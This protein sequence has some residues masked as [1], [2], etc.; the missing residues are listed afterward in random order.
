MTSRRRV[1]V[2]VAL[3]SILAGAALLGVCVSG[4]RSLNQLQDDRERVLARDV[5]ALQAAQEAALRLRQLRYHGFMYV[6]EPTDEHRIPVE[7]D[8]A[9]FEAAIRRARAAADQP[10]EQEIIDRI[11]TNY[12]NYRRDIDDPA[13]R[14]TPPVS[15]TDAVAW[16]DTHHVSPLLVPC[17]ELLQINRES[18]ENTRRENAGL[19]ARASTWMVLLAVGGA[20]GGVLLGGGVAWGL[21]RS[22]TRL[23]VWLQSA[24]RE[25]DLGSVRVTAAGAPDD[26]DRLTSGVVD[27]IRAAVTQLQEQERE[28]LRREQLAAVGQLAAGLAHEI[29]NPL[30]G[31]KLLIEAALRPNGQLTREE[32][33]MTL[34]EMQRIERTVQG[35][36]DFAR[37]PTPR[38]A[39]VELIGLIRRAVDAVESR[40]DLHRVTVALG[41]MPSHVPV[42]GDPDQLTSLLANLLINGIEAT[43]AGGTV[44]VAVEPDGAERVRV[45]VTDT[46][47]GIDPTVRAKLFTPF[48]TTKPTGT[49][50]G[51]SV[52]RRIA[53]AHG[54][55]LAVVDGADSASG[56]CFVWTIPA[57]EV[58]NAEAADRR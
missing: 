49:G 19:T 32:L 57:D 46:G 44:T 21:S 6:L 51:L 54:G 25:L 35:L 23:R 40:A 30:T 50:L 55:T 26:L 17:E 45:S 2:L 13:K 43:P 1:V 37:A 58:T 14:P 42:T 47:P 48:A 18:I 24:H 15:R 12:R 34:G 27:R 41:P 20:A 28:L 10:R 38:R 3:P 7:R 56:A 22:M 31:V 36:L 33:E 8:H 53:E 11:E 4:V 52:A 9:Q 16:G 29:R 5:E 39:T